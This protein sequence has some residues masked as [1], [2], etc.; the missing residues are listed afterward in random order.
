VASAVARL[1]E[2]TPLPGAEQ[3]PVY[4]DVIRRLHDALAESG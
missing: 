3:V 1:D 4:E 2:L